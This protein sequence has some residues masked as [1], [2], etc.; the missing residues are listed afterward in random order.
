MN[1]YNKEREREQKRGRK[2]KGRE[3]KRKRKRREK[4][5]ERKQTYLK[6]VPNKVSF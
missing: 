3:N 1:K 5:R 2:E 6:V 4:G